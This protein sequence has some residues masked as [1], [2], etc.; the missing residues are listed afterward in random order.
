MIFYL[1]E[2]ESIKACF[3]AIFLFFYFFSAVE[4]AR[5]K[6]IMEIYEPDDC[7]KKYAKNVD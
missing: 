4:L 3:I 6:D 2:V 1:A 5:M 7:T